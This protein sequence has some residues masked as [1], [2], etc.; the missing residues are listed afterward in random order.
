MINWFKDKVVLNC[1]AGS[2]QNAKEIYEAANGHALIGVL[3]SK[4]KDISSA[5]ED[6][7]IYNQELNGNLSV[8][9][10]GG[11]PAQWKAVGDIAKEV[12][13]D[14]FNQVFTAVAYTRANVGN[15]EA[16]V[17]VLVAPT[18][19]P[20]L[21]KIST[22]PLSSKAK[23]PAIVDVET[24]I[25]MAKDMGGSSLK[26]F[27]MHGLQALNELKVLSDVCARNNFIVEPTG[28]IDLDNFE[29]I[30]SVVLDAGVKKVIPHVYSSIIDKES[31]NTRIEDVEKIFSIIDKLVK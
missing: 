23:K 31:G 17:N 1:L 14:H 16:L 24:A 20:G 25:L 4:Y 22:G 11:N 19:T 28:G 9:L 5:I 27:P 8:G 13:A 12:K 21:V 6:M 18:G 10:G 26:F 29:E 7:R 30:L 2:H 3:S 15:D